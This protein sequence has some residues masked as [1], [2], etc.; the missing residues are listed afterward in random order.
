MVIFYGLKPKQTELT[1]AA[2]VDLPQDGEEEEDSDEG[3]LQDDLHA[4]VLQE[5]N[6]EQEEEETKIQRRFLKK[7]S[8]FSKWMRA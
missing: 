3:N 1:V 4:Q 7:M 8:L 5:V 6:L 2:A